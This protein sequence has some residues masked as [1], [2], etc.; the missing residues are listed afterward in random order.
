MIGLSTLQIWFRSLPQLWKLGGI[1]TVQRRIGKAN[2]LNL[3]NHPAAPHQKYIRDCI[4][5]W[6]S[7]VDSII[8][9][10]LP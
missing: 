2:V 6:S 1:K 3:P 10:T 8:P 7:N 5:G 9:P 4:L